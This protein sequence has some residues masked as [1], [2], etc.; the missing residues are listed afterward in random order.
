MAWLLR[1]G[2]VLAA[3]EVADGFAGRSRGLLGRDGI[4][5]AI[6]IKPARSVHTVGMRFPIDVAFCDRDMTVVDAITMPRFRVSR[7]RLRARCVVEAEAGAFER[8]GLR[9]GDRLEIKGDG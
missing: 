7:P 1:G 3:L 4:E 8:W 2:E 9:P 5:G 6:L